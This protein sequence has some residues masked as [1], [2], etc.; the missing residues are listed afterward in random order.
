MA[1]SVPVPIAIPT[2]ACGQRGRV[3]H[4]VAGHRD[5]V[6]LRLQ[7]LHDFAFLIRQHFCVDLIDFQF[8]RD[9]FGG[10]AAV[11]GEH[12]DRIPSR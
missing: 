10:R 9:G 3:V 12:H 11:A 5:D 1:T 6:S 7:L 8:S 4:A 2:L